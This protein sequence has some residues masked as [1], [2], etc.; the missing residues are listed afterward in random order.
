MLVSRRLWRLRGVVVGGD[1]R[2]V[3][4][5]MTKKL[6][7]ELRRS[8]RLAIRA[9]RLANDAEEHARGAQWRA[10]TATHACQKAAESETLAH[11][12]ESVN[13]VID[14]HAETSRTAE[15]ELTRELIAF[16]EFIGVSQ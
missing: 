9:R 5:A 3:G 13:A 2:R 15:V 4:V 7:T 1:R 12:L 11:Y 10:W 14:G 16:G 8:V 6:A